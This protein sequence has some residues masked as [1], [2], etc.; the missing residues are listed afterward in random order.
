MAQAAAAKAA[1]TALPTFKQYRESDGKFYFKLVAPGGAVL[2]QSPAFDSP[3]EPGQLIARLKR[4]DSAAI[5][6]V[7][8]WWLA[9]D[10]PAVVIALLAEAE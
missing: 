6:E 9:A 1:K 3:R 8:P 10:A 2:L 5:A 7:T 4:Q